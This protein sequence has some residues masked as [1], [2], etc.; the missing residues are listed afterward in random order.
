MKLS[1][2]RIP[3]TATFTQPALMLN[4]INIWY[5]D[6]NIT[7]D[8]DIEYRGWPTEDILILK[9]NTQLVLT[10]KTSSTHFPFE[11]R[12]SWNLSVILKIW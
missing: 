7:S 4:W 9:A 6:I 5:T 8:T 2:F 1:T 10:S 12:W 3:V 11:V